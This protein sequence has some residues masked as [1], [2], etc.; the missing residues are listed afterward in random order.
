[1]RDTARRYGTCPTQVLY[2]AAH[3]YVR[4]GDRRWVSPRLLLNRPY[5]V[6]GTGK[7][8]RA[9]LLDLGRLRWGTADPQAPDFDCRVTVA[10]D[11]AVTEL[12]IRWALPGF[13]DPSRHRVVVPWPDGTVSHRRVGALGI[14][15]AGSRFEYDWEDWTTVD[16]HERRKAGWDA[17]A[18]AFRERR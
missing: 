14:E 15:L 1:M 2:G 13:S 17:L 7:R 4:V 5:T 12:R 8:R 3:G 10:G 16:W 18:R 9:E 11:E 6:P